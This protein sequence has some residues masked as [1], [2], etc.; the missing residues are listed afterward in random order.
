[1]KPRWIR[2]ALLPAA[3]FAPGFAQAH[4]GAHPHTHLHG[5]AEGLIHPFTGLDHLLA[6]VAVGLWAAS[7]GGRAR[8]MAPASFV[9]MMALGAIGA[10]FGLAPPTYEPAIAVSVIA[11]GLLVAFQVKAPAFA[12]A[13]LVG[14]FALAHGFAHGAEVA[15]DAAFVSYA[16]G[17]AAATAFLHAIGL[18]F[19][20]L[21]LRGGFASLT[22]QAA[23]LSTAAAGVCLAT[24]A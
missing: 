2:S 18:T 16:L 12:A 22:M 5:L 11:L 9:G 3:L 23:G 6:M 17:F 4:V 19:G 20:A 7:L 24:F 15:N 13:T 1:M 10:R 21:G 14:L 8:W